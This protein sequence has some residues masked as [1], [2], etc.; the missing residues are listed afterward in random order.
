MLPKEKIIKLDCREKQNRKELMK[1]LKRLSFF[2]EIEKPSTTDLEKYVFKIIGKTL[3]RI[4]G[5]MITSNDETI[6]FVCKDKNGNNFMVFAK[7]ITEGYMKFILY[8]C[9]GKIQGE[10][11]GK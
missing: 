6:T 8:T 4:V 11:D 7:S 3:N 10:N 5:I 1:Y 9:Y 2:S